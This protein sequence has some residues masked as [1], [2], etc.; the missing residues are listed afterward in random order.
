MS[1]RMASASTSSPRSSKKAPTGFLN[2]GA[3]P[4]AEIQIDGKPWPYQTPQAG[5]ELKA[6][7]HTVTL[8]N[9]ETGVTKTT[10]VYIKSGAYRTVMMDMRKR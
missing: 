7:K 8:H 6:G 3:K 2:V 4:W 1:C 5:I 9:P 10:A